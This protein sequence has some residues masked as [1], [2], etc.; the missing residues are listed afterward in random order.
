MKRRQAKTIGREGGSGH[1]MEGGCQVWQ[2]DQ[3]G[4]KQNALQMQD[5][6]KT[7]EIYKT[8]NSQMIRERDVP[9]SL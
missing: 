9:G 4:R 5:D 1:Q 6:I 2:S 7:K 3:R 8:Y